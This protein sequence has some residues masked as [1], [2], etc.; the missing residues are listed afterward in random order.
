MPITICLIEWARLYNYKTTYTNN[1]YDTIHITNFIIYFYWINLNIIP[2]NSTR[3]FECKSELEQYLL[4]DVEVFTDNFHI[5]IWW[6]VNSTKYPFLSTMARN[7]LA[8]RITIVASKSMVNI[9]GHFLDSFQSPWL[10][11]L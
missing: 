8:I 7:I 2:F 4:E 9:G 5:F 1:E 11:E 6:R 3:L 10:L